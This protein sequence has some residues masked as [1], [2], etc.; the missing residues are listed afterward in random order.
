MED[1]GDGQRSEGP[2]PPLQTAGMVRAMSSAG[3]NILGLTLFLDTNQIGST[4]KAS[5]FLARLHAE[6]CISVLV[7]DTVGTELDNSPETK[8]DDLSSAA[9]QF[10][11]V[12]GVMVLDHSR[13]DS[14]VL[15]GE[16]DVVLMDELRQIIYP[17]RDWASVR[18]Q[19]TRDVM[20]IHTAIRAGADAFVTEDHELLKRSHELIDH[21]N[22]WSPREAAVEAVRRLREASS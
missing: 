4:L 10:D 12:L 14:A 9:S 6:G 19:H 2:L 5:R 20:H 11:V 18:R 17:S 7:S 3:E 13:L 1:L 8:R 16:A 15:G 21:I 22:V